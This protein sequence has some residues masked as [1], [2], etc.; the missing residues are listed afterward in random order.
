MSDIDSFIEFE[1]KQFFFRSSAGSHIPVLRVVSKFLN[2]KSI[3]ELGSGI[4]SLRTFLDKKY[5]PLLERIYSYETDKTWMNYIK[6]TFNDCRLKITLINQCS[7]VNRIHMPKKADIVFLDGT[8]D[9]RN[10][11]IEKRK[12]LSD[13]FILHDCDIPL[14]KEKLREFRYQFVYS[15]PVGFRHTAILSDKINVAEIKWDIKWEDDFL[16]WV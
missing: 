7:D 2:V 1:G 8:S 15:P 12:N 14:H 9:Q 6:S 11:V 3:I 10:A 16:K 5:F 4:Y 13:V